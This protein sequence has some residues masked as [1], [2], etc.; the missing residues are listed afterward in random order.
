MYWLWLST[1]TQ[2]LFPNIHNI[3]ILCGPQVYGCLPGG[4]YGSLALVFLFPKLGKG[5]GG[6]PLLI[7]ITWFRAVRRDKEV[8][9]VFLEV[10]GL[11]ISVAVLTTFLAIYCQF[12]CQLIQDL[13][14]HLQGQVDSLTAI[15]LYYQCILDLPTAER[16]GLVSFSKRNVAFMSTNRV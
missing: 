9:D 14:H 10:L 12:S 4:W 1:A 2:P 11:A 6:E 7:P 15:V 16:G 5:P 8:V 13:H 3:L